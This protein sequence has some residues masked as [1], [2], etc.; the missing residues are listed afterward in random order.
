MRPFRKQLKSA[1]VQYRSQRYPGNLAGE[2]LAGQSRSYWLIA[3]GG[4][5]AA[6]AAALLIYLGTIRPMRKTS[7]PS[8]VLNATTQHRLSPTASTST[9]NPLIPNYIEITPP[10]ESF[11]VPA[12]ELVPSWSAIVYSSHSGSS[13]ST[14]RES[15]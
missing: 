3:I 5:L 15:A 6:I 13:T 12:I 1:K 4:S 10:A 2:I 7:V 8:I 11:S 14:T 9:D